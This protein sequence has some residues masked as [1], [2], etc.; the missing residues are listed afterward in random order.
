MNGLMTLEYLKLENMAENFDAL[1]TLSECTRPC[2]QS[3]LPVHS[4]LC[5]ENFSSD[6]IQLPFHCAD[7][8]ILD[9]KYIRHA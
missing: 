6:I 8:I 5:H 3:D 9:R 1:A 2:V 7:D 4:L